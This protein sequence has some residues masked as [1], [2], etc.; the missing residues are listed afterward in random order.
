MFHYDSLEDDHDHTLG[1]MQWHSRHRS[2][3]QQGLLDGNKS[4]ESNWLH[5]QLEFQPLSDQPFD[6][7]DTNA[8]IGSV[9]TD[10]NSTD[11]S[12]S[13]QPRAHLHSQ[14]EHDSQDMDEAED[15]WTMDTAT[16]A[17]TKYN[18]LS[19]DTRN[20]QF[21]SYEQTQ[22][23]YRNIGT[24]FV[25]EVPGSLF[26]PLIRRLQ[27]SSSTVV[28]HESEL[29][30]SLIQAITGLP[31]IYFYWDQQQNVFKQRYMHYRILGVSTSAIQPVLDQVLL[32]GTRVKGLEF[33]SQQCQAQPETYGLTGMAFGCCLLDL[34]M[35]IQQTVVSVFSVDS[36]ESMT[37]LKLYHSVQSLATVV[38]K[39]YGL[40]QIQ[41]QQQQ[42]MLPKG[43]SLLNLLHREISRFD[44][45]SDGG[46]SALYRDICLILLSYTSVPYSSMMSRWLHFSNNGSDDPL[47]G[48]PYNEFFIGERTTTNK[49]DLLQ[50]YKIRS[51]TELPYFIDK[52]LA[53]YILRSGISVRLL[54]LSKPDHPLFDINDSIS[55]E[56]SVSSTENE[57]YLF[58]LQRVCDYIRSYNTTGL[59]AQQQTTMTTV[60][61]NDDHHTN[62]DTMQ[63]DMPTLPPL[64]DDTKQSDFSIKLHQVLQDEAN[65]SIPTFDTMTRQSYIVPI[66]TWCPLLNE[67]F[68]ISFLNQFKLQSHL[69][70]LYRYFLFGNGTFVNGLKA[71]FFAKI[72]L[73]HMGDCWP[74]KSFSLNLALQSLLL[75]NS[76]HEYDDL[77]TFF[78][79]KTTADSQWNH[80]HA[81]EA[82]NFLQLHYDAT[83]PLNMVI[84]PPILDKYNRIFTFLIQLL[85]VA[86]VIKRC[87]EPLR[88]MRWYK[89]STRDAICRYRF[90]MDQ[91]TSALQSYIHDTAIEGT[92]SSFMQHVQAMQS[93]QTSSNSN[94]SSSKDYVSV[95]MEPH[96]FRDYH[97]HVLDRILF[98]CFL[99]QSQTRI[100]KVLRPIL[101]DIIFFSAILDDYAVKDMDSEDKLNMKCSRIFDQFKNHSR[102]FISVLQL[103]ETKGSGRLTN[104]L[105]STR[106]SIFND[107]YARHEAKNGMDV[108]VKD[109]LTRLALNGYYSN[110]SGTEVP[111]S[112]FNENSSFNDNGDS[113]TNFTR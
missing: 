22:L 111:F 46:N 8:S 40:C 69:S 32:F 37:V 52:E 45:A 24:P 30:K 16:H 59:I 34:L 91:F 67:S 42:F 25:T 106:P 35:H 105:N 70:L 17:P 113:D 63:H 4:L 74:P 99:K 98:Q 103:L 61:N 97:E 62:Q 110:R 57:E 50:G 33:V 6:F 20:S 39:L 65:H 41:Q 27:D 64:A 11:T 36:S 28:I 55:L 23:A 75:E 15:I 100:F 54:K 109:L 1:F 82:L 38:D 83:Y 95:I 18:T 80:P 5:E 72:G 31:S 93:Q 12:I 51:D 43:A 44:L 73:N 53:L 96:S 104:V 58:R 76:Q 78:V 49:R 92:W 7:L 102:V 84:T 13:Q 81:V 85:R 90:Q 94:S 87:F 89:T 66:Q 26:E 79:R 77:V 10:G 107:L 21:P 47:Y 101:Q 68:M 108:F 88:N 56:F 9:I 71:T 19:W 112:S 29:V 60:A 2:Q 14:E 3:Q 48:D 86:T